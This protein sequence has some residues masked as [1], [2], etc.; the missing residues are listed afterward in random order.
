MEMPSEFTKIC[1]E[2][3]MRGR[4]NPCFNGKCSQSRIKD[5]MLFNDD[6]ES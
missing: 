2:T 6:E 4:L 3:A 1:T 5:W